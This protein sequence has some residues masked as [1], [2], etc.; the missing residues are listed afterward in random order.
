VSA[1][2]AMV[3]ENMQESLQLL[4]AKVA[5]ISLQLS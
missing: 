3:Q 4:A 1:P 2:L 5:L